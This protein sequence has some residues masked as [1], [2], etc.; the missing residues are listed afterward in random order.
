MSNKIVLASQEIEIEPT[1]ETALA[2]TQK[3]RCS[4][5]YCSSVYKQPN[6]QCSRPDGHT[7]CHFFADNYGIIIMMW[8]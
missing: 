8:W 1:T 3:E 4:S 7:N 2:M 5:V 6:I